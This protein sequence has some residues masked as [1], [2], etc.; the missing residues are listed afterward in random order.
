MRSVCGSVVA[1]EIEQ[2]QQIKNGKN[3]PIIGNEHEIFID[4]RRSGSYSKYI[5]RIGT[6][7]QRIFR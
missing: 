2:V 4:L 3:S 7:W 1:A 5:V 6:G